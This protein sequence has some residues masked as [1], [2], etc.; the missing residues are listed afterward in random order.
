MSTVEKGISEKN[1]MGRKKWTHKAE[2]HTFKSQC[3]SVCFTFP[4][5]CLYVCI[6][7]LKKVV[8]IYFC[9]IVD[10]S[11]LVCTCLKRV[12][13]QPTCFVW[14]NEAVLVIRT[15]VLQWKDITV[16]PQLAHLFQQLA[17]QCKTDTVA[18]LKLTACFQGQWEWSGSRVGVSQ[19][20]GEYQ[21]VSFEIGLI[22]LS[23]ISHLEQKSYGAGK[24]LDPF[25]KL[26]NKQ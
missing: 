20:R 4:L 15:V 21:Q 26:L 10:W 19:L 12:W 6:T 8:C 11:K 22:S 17:Q 23:E 9:K 24:W 18:G 7:S 25:F 5:S 13:N 3:V 14:E 1:G 16:V 2:K